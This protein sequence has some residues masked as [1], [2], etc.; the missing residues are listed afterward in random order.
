MAKV[1]KAGAGAATTAVV[2]FKSPA[3]VLKP[4][5]F[6]LVGASERG[7]WPAQIFRN[8]KEQHFPGRLLLVNPRQKEVF[9]ERCYPSLAELP[10]APEHAAI[11]VPADAVAGVLEDAHAAGVKS[12]T[13]YAAGIGDGRDPK[14]KARGAWLAEFI[15]RSGMRISGPNCMGAMSYRERLFAYPNA[16][17]ATLPAGPIGIVFQSGGTLQFF[18]QSGADRGLRYSYAISSGN[19]PDLD[20]ADYVNFL[21]DD[22]ETHTI[23]LF[24]EGIRRPD[25]FMAVA[26]RAL[27]A[28]KPI[29]AIKTGQSQGSAAAA[30][31]H[32]GAIAG[33]YAAFLAMCERCGIVV[34]RSLDDLLETTLAFQCRRWPKG[35]RIGF[36][37]TS[38]GTV[39]LL[40]DY[41]EREGATL[42]PFSAATKAALQPVMQEGI[43]PKNPLDV[44]IPSNNAA[45][46]EWC[47]I[48]L[49]DDQ[50]DM[51]GWAA[52]LP[53]KQGG[54]GD[55]SALTGMHQ[56]TDKPVLGFGRMVY[57]V[58]PEVVT[59]QDTFGFPFLQGL[60]PTVRAMNALWFYAQR[61]GRLPASLPAVKPSTLT[62]ETLDAMLADYGIMLPRRRFA[63]TPAEAAVL[64]L[65]ISFPLAL[66]IQSRDILHKTE[67]GGVVLDLRS[68]ETV[69]MA[70][71]KLLMAARAR[72]RAARIDGFLLQ[73]MV[74]GVETIVGARADPLYGPMLLVGSGGVLVE[75]TGDAAL[76]MLP[77]D[78]AQV[79]GMVDQVK[80]SRLLAGYRGRPTAD[81]AALEAAMLA[82]ARFY[83]DHRAVLADIE[84]NP[85][86]VRADGKGAVAV[87]VRAIWK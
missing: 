37:T 7:N 62:P 32:T 69:E 52:Q 50:V 66:K 34:C 65:D 46:A 71:A 67:V 14:S 45:A 8:L 36:V 23:V 3:S 11:I 85:L 35:P 80:L 82:L 20:L 4:G 42:A 64:A 70:A 16:A 54:F 15:A 29:L 40:Y 53:R 60:E 63:A 75:I 22:P 21:V 31:S 25:A 58:T 41:V 5:S 47:R 59:A 57:Q 12:A 10:E 44:G 83:L 43:E 30:Q 24:I 79:A 6:A 73:E 51:L 78:G 81:R 2:Q 28:G 19:E 77:V 74:H 61:R 87:D 76:R 26:G 86:V 56:G 18:M 55:V 9:G 33:D 68:P 1:G 38:G 84:I 27:A 39:D 72:N 49:A 13:L 17:L 48:V